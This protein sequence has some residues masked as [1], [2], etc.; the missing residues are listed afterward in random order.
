[1]AVRYLVEAFGPNEPMG[2][3]ENMIEGL[4][5]S[6]ALRELTNQS[7]AEFQ[8]DF[9]AW[10]KNWEDPQRAEVRAYVNIL[11][12]IMD[13]QD[14]ISERRAK[15]L[16]SSLSLSQSIA[17]RSALVTDA[18]ALVSSLNSMSLPSAMFDVHEDALAYLET[19]VEWLA[20]ELEY[21]QTSIDAKRV[22]AND[23][24]PE[25]NAR[26]STLRRSINTAE[27]IYQ[28]DDL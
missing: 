2:V 27:F 6:E 1:M 28:L 15:N 11:N 10:L 9:F 20:L 8:D 4:S 13:S 14:A 23:M 24:I 5:L 3:I 26:E 18:Q 25:I 12:D 7:Y 22:Q 17:P 21:A 19:F 16:E